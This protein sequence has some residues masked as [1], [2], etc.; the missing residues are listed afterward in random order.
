MKIT[1]LVDDLRDFREPRSCLIARTSEA[2]IDLLEATP[3]V[4]YESIWLDHDLGGDD[5]TMPVVDYLIERAQEGRPVP[6][7]VIYVHSSNPVGKRNI[8]RALENYRHH[9]PVF[10]I[11]ASGILAV[12]ASKVA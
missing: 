5:T 12:T 3:G 7:E 6:V 1:L 8:A 10:L 4:T 9:Y 11:P 2:A